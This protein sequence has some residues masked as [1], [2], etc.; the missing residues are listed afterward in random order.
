MTAQGCAENIYT[1][2]GS[3]RRQCRE[4]QKSK[5]STHET[6]VDDLKRTFEDNNSNTQKYMDE[7]NTKTLRIKELIETLIPQAEKSFND[8]YKFC[9]EW[10]PSSLQHLCEKQ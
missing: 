2:V 3:I 6:T 4:D 5:R 1:N 8:S 10:C 7:W 9:K